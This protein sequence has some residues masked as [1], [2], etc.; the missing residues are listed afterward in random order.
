MKIYKE[1]VLIRKQQGLLELVSYFDT[2]TKKYGINVYFHD[3]LIEIIQPLE[4]EPQRHQMRYPWK[5][6]TRYP[7]KYSDIQGNREA[8]LKM[9]SIYLK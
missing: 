8:D 6:N 9:K 5:S 7:W 3:K 4:A 1:A 2:V